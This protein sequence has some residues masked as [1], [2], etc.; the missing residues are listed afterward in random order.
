MVVW[1]SIPALYV[2]Y[3]SKDGKLTQALNIAVL[4][5]DVIP[6]YLHLPATDLNNSDEIISL[7]KLFFTCQG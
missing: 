5:G 6:L 3:S 1:L 7:K 2:G 4:E